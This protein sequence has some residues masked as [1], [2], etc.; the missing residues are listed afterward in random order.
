[1]FFN[2]VGNWFCIL[3]IEFFSIEKFIVFVLEKFIVNLFV[4]NI[5]I[6]Y[7]VERF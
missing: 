1:M 3:G 2:G 7:F 6:F 5:K 4:C